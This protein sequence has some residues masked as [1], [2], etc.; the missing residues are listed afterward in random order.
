MI[1]VKFVGRM[2]AWDNLGGVVIM[3][4]VAMIVVVVIHGGKG[5]M[6]HLLQA[7]TMTAAQTVAMGIALEISSWA[8]QLQRSMAMLLQGW[9]WE[10]GTSWLP[11]VDGGVSIDALGV[12]QG[13]FFGQSL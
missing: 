11:W 13:I 5:I 1:V 8:R 7:K 12:G 3:M 10:Q 6:K 4:M 2:N 9:R